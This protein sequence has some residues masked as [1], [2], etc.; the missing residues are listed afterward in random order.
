[1]ADRYAIIASRFNSEITDKLVAGAL[2][3]FGEHGV[4]IDTITVVRVP[5][6][7][8]IPITAK[9]LASSGKYAAIVCLGAVINGDTDHY[10]YVCRAAADGILQAGM[11][12]GV[13]VMFGVLVLHGVPLATAGLKQAPVVESQVPA[14]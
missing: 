6:A 9:R 1:M 14:L 2:G 7:F 5:G 13:P 10:E 11:E 4:P 3:A 8:E 12:T